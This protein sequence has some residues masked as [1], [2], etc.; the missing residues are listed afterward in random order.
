[1]DAISDGKIIDVSGS[2]NDLVV[3]GVVEVTNYSYKLK[4][5]IGKRVHESKVAKLEGIFDSFVFIC[6]SWHSVRKKFQ[7]DLIVKKSIKMMS[8]N[9]TKNMEK[10]RE[11]SQN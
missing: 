7:N 4:T 5:P 6:N 1:M 10:G 8:K 9:L 11:V 2:G 3:H